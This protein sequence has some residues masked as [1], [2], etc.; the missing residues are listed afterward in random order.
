MIHAHYSH[1]GSRRKVDKALKDDFALLRSQFS[2]ADVLQTTTNDAVTEPGAQETQAIASTGAIIR[3]RM[4]IRHCLLPNLP[5]VNP[6]LAPLPSSAAAA[7]GAEKA[8]DLAPKQPV[9]VIAKHLCGVATDL[10]IHSVRS[11]PHIPVTHTES[12]AA[13]TLLWLFCGL[14]LLRNY[15]FITL[16]LC[17]A[18]HI[19]EGVAGHQVGLAIATCCHHACQFA[20]YAGKEWFLAQGFT[21]A[22]FEVLKKWSGWANS[23]NLNI[24][25]SLQQQ[26]SAG[27]NDIKGVD[28]RED[29][30]TQETNQQVDNQDD[31]LDEEQAEVS[32]HQAPLC[33]Q[34]MR[35]ANITPPEMQLLGWQVKRIFDHGRV[36]YINRYYNMSARQIR[37]CDRILSPECVML[38]AR[39]W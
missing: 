1:T 32:A 15:A 36:E 12:T 28:D 20:D 24:T 7:E 31:N 35:P 23:V 37:Y 6:P 11:F 13:G 27:K 25:A 29:L 10:A 4:D 18:L 14:F 8:G 38:L 33:P 3:A 34:V 39:E 17:G 2:P 26:T 22:E 16:H 5:G 21:A 30:S 9:V 19:S